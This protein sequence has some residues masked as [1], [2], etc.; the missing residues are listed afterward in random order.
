MST[1]FWQIQELKSDLLWTSES[2]K[3]SP[4]ILLDILRK[5]S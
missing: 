5:S 4:V 3:D 2:I 1:K